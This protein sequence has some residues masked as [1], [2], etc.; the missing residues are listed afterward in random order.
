MSGC[1]GDCDCGSGCKC[2]RGYGGC[3]CKMY[4]DM[5]FSEGSTTTETIIAGTLRDLR[6][7]WEQRTDASAETTAS[8]IPA[9]ANETTREETTLE[10]GIDNSMC[11]LC[12]QDC[13][14]EAMHES[15]TTPGST[16]T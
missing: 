3:G 10:E 1:G 6:W 8:V 2:G 12:V 11:V 9:L 14:F 5:S 13:E 4:R 15:M 7:A 16:P